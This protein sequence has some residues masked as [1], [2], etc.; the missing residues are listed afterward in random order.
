MLIENQQLRTQLQ[1]QQGH[2]KKKDEM[3]QQV[4]KQIF[5]PTSAQNSQGGDFLQD[6]HNREIHHNAGQAKAQGGAQPR[7]S[8]AKIVNN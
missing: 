6:F 8:A 7:I 3:V 5:H 1:S 2:I 4:M